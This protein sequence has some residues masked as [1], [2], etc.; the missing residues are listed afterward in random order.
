MRDWRGARMLQLYTFGGLRIERDGRP[1]QLPTHKARDLLAYL[2]TFRDRPHP[3]PVLAGILWPDLP[4]EKA[5]R[6]L[7][8]TLWRVRRATGPDVILADEDTLAFNPACDHW[9]DV[10]E[11]EDRA[12]AAG[13]QEQ[14][15]TACLSLYLGTFL[16][17]LYHDW[18]LLE[19]ERLHML[20]LESLG[21]LLELHK[22]AGDYESGLTIAQRIVAVEPLHEAAH[23]ELMRFY[24]LL[25]RDAE[26]VAQY[27]R[28]RE[29]L[30]E[31]LDVA[32][33]SET[34]SLYHGLSRRVSSHV[35]VPAM[36]LP[37]PARRPVPDLDELPLVG[38]DT[39]RAALL[40]HLEAAAAGQ[41]GIVL[42]EGEPG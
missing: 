26:A 19:R 31:E 15:T 22:Q 41:G 11:F 18:V 10:E 33:A 3:R 4:E 24:H 38:R 2:I 37:A 17:G 32:P 8:D 23:R 13:R 30:R 29:M 9:L 34:E 40:R 42:L 36:H 25:G 27:H 21:R 39:E 16:D 20:Y 7:S 14:A 1:L 6:R 35:G 5:R 12:R 28:C